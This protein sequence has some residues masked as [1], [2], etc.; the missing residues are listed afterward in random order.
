MTLRSTFT[1]LYAEAAARQRDDAPGESYAALRHGADIKV[2]VQGRRRQIILG[3]QGAPVGEGEIVTFR[4]DGSIPPEA[5]RADY[6][7]RRWHYVA[8]SW[9]A[10]PSL[11]EGMPEAELPASLGAPPATDPADGLKDRYEIEY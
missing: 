6:Q 4:R 8:L 11:F 9:E 2:R 7:A 10:A 3:R 5:T 1:R